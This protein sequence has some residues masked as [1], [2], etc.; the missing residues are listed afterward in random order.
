[1]RFMKLP[2]LTVATS[3][4]AVL[5][6]TSIGLGSCLALAAG[7]TGAVGDGA[8][9]S[10]GDAGA[11]SGDG[12]SAA[13]T[14]AATSSGGSGAGTTSG[15]GGSSDAEVCQR[16]KDDRAAMSEGA[17][18]G[19]L[20]SC[21]AGDVAEPGRG[22]ALRIVNL[23]RWL[24]A[25]PPVSHE[26]GFNQAAQECALMMHKNG[27]LSHTPPMSWGCYSSLGASGAGT[28]NIATAPGVGAV[29]LYMIDPGNPTTIGHRRWILSGSLGPIGLGS[30]SGYSC[31][32]VLG[33][34][35]SASQS[36]TAWPPAGRIPFAAWNVSFQSLDETGWTVQSE[37]IALAGAVVSVAEDG[38]DRPVQTVE[39]MGGFGSAHALRFNPKGWQT[40]A[41]H[42]YHVSVSGGSSPIEY[43]VEVLA[44]P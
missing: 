34:S 14:A 3:R 12:G 7:C 18:S 41:G 19:A 36:F 26:A 30:T 10:G 20:E 39:L 16:W 40:S 32:K 33:G 28:S 8:S 6:L 15:G 43:D 25:L 11:T 22:N 23:Y 13:S 29:D 4:A 37:S 17:W 24:A 2:L 42:T 27:Q 1:M 21:D 35:G 44:C 5:P 9:G 31:M 38:I